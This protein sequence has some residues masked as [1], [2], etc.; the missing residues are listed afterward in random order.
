MATF[1]NPPQRPGLHE[2]P[3]LKVPKKNKFPWPLVAIVIAAAILVALIFWLPRTP[4]TQMPP[5]AAQVPAQPTGNQIQFTNLKMTPAPVG[6][7]FYLEGQLVNHGNTDITG[8]QVQA[9]FKNITGQTLETQVRPVEGIVGTSGAQTQ[10]LT[11]API[12]PNQARPIRVSFN[13]Y[14]DGWNKQIP[15][16]KVVAVTAHGP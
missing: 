14:P 1:P 6:N 9:T 7:A 13:Q 8:V 12:K 3:R 11:A 5:S 15:E 2:V 16:L 4:H 10:D